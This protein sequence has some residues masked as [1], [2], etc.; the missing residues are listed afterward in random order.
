MQRTHNTLFLL[1]S[2][3]GKISTGIGNERGMD[4]DYKRIK[5]I[6]EGVKQYY[7]L[8]QQ[9]D[10]FSLNTGKTMVKIGANDN[11]PVNNNDVTFIIVDNNH[12]ARQDILN[13][14]SNLKKL[15]LV[16]RNPKHPALSI[17]KE[18][19]ETILYKDEIDFEDLFIKL[20][21]DYGVK[22]VTVQ[23]GGTL[24]SVFL[25]EKLIDEL[26]IVVAPAL[27]GGK[28]TPTLIDGESL[29]NKEDLKYIKALKLKDVKIL[30]D[31]FLHL[32]YKII[33]RTRV[34]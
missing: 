34:D 33:N 30:K 21:N 28:E 14:S 13:M 12:L 8:E 27:V 17:K 10:L 9:T 2:V 18:N 15:I 6:K 29:I 23:S 20:K 22:R 24:N 31:S 19:L 4:K 3:D 26:S 32:T 7:E 25:R 5:G 16:T 11:F 1:I